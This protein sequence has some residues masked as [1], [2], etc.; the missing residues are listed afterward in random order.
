MNLSDRL[1]IVLVKHWGVFDVNKTYKQLDDSRMYAFLFCLLLLHYMYSF[2]TKKILHLAYT[3]L[4]SKLLKRRFNISHL[5]S[6]AF[7]TCNTTFINAK[8]YENKLNCESF[9]YSCDN[10]TRKKSLS[11]I[12]SRFLRPCLLVLEN[13]R[14]KTTGKRVFWH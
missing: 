13:V 14:L 4:R 2:I 3:I 1:L 9:N 6:L 11:E 12:K 5:F 10:W 7:N 8:I